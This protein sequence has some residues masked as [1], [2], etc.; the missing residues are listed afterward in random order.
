MWPSS[1]L[2]QA[3]RNTLSCAGSS[4]QPPYQPLHCRNTLA[5]ASSSKQPP[6]QTF[7]CRDTLACAG[8]IQAPYP[9]SHSPLPGFALDRTPLPSQVPYTL[10]PVSRC[11]CCSIL[12]SC[13]RLIRSFLTD[14]PANSLPVFCASAAA[15]RQRQ[16]LGLATSAHPSWPG[17]CLTASFFFPRASAGAQ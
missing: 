17:L 12:C 4:K 6:F 7:L 13:L 14:A 10:A 5:C 15:Q 9:V 11:L 16:A 2:A 3:R 1:P 8:R